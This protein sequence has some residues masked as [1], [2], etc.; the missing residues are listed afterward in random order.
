MRKRTSKK[1][2][3]GLQ[4]IQWVFNAAKSI[5]ITFRIPIDIQIKEKLTNRINNPLCLTVP[6]EKPFYISKSPNIPNGGT[7]NRI[8]KIF[9]FYFC[10]DSH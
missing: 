1:L 6:P 5:H 7:H 10:R 3:R 8:P 2:E 9:Y 4:K